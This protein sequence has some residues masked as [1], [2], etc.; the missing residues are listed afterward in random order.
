MQA[1]RHHLGGAAQVFQVQAFVCAFGVGLEHGAGACAVEH[2][3]DAGFA[4]DAHVGVKR[5]AAG[6]DGFLEQLSGVALQRVGQGLVAGQVPS[7][8]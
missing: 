6:R 5:C 3:G 4:E 7:A 2:A 8:R 1:A